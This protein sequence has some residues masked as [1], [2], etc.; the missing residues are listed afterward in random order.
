MLASEES[1]NNASDVININLTDAPDVEAGNNI[2]L[3][4]S[5]TDL[6]LAG[7]VSGITT[8]GIWTTEGNGAFDDENDLNTM[9]HVSPEEFT[10]GG[11]TL[12]LTSVN[13]ANCLAIVDSVDVIYTSG[14]VSNA[15]SDQ[16]VCEGSESTPLNGIVSNGSTSGIWTTS[17][18]GTFSDDTDLNSIYSFSVADSIAGNF[19]IYLTSTNNGDCDVAID[20]IEVVFGT[21]PT[22]IAGDD[23]NICGLDTTVFLSGF[24]SG[25][26]PSAKLG[27][28]RNWNI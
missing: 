28:V 24:I 5:N 7:L 23:I 3:C 25:V 22:V 14:I 6:N 27:N 11:V 15:G 16:N 19:T 18:T 1:C 10:D 21:S 13:N 12:Y 26:N 8:D 20:S 4:S 2:V 17:G 9:Y